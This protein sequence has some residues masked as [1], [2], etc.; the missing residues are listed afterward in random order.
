MAH[1]YLIYV[2]SPGLD[3]ME[4]IIFQQLLQPCII[5]AIQN[6]VKNYDIFQRKNSQNNIIDFPAKLAENTLE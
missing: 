3:R 2:L 1:W 5:E 6:G 4:A